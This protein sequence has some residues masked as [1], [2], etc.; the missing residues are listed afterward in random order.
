MRSNKPKSKTAR[1]IRARLSFSGKLK[2]RP[3]L[4][5]WEARR[6]AIESAILRRSLE[7][8]FAGSAKAH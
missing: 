7:V 1:S 5:A 6:R 8:G 4:S 3:S 2:A